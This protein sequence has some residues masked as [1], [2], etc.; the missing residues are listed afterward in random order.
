MSVIFAGYE[1]Q[2]GTPIVARDGCGGLEV[3]GL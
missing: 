1:I 3:S 2:E